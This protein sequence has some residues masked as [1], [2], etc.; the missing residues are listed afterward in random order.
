MLKQACESAAG[1]SDVLPA[2]GLLLIS[3]KPYA[4]LLCVR[5]IFPSVRC[6]KVRILGQGAGQKSV[7]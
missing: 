5:V 1:W 3:Q 4:T 6:N 2:L 7:P